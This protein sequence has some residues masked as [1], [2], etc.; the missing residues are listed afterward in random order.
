MV[1]IRP[2]RPV[3][4]SCGLQLPSTGICEPATNSTIGSAVRKR[5]EAGKDLGGRPRRV[6]DSQIRSAV[7]LVKGGEPAGQV[8]RDLGMPERRSTGGHLSEAAAGWVVVA[9]AEFDAVA[10]GVVVAACV[11]PGVGGCFAAGRSGGFAP[12]VVTVGS[13]FS[14]RAVGEY[15]GPGMYSAEWWHLRCFAALWHQKLSESCIDALVAAELN[16]AR[17][18]HRAQ[19]YQEKEKAMTLKRAPMW[20]GVIVLG[21]TLG[22]A[23]A[24]SATI[25]PLVE[26]A[27]CANAQADSH[28]PLGDV[29]DPIGATPGE[30]SHSDQ[31][32]LRAVIVI[33]DGFTDLTSPAL[34]GHKL[35]ETCGK[36]G[37]SER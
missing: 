26:S 5:R 25:H 15:P 36:V 2:G 32:T 24:A 18:R 28:H 23:P 33:S 1:K 10:G 12:G 21:T 30:G 4:D 6:T 34:L 14:L 22:W 8:A 13:G 35:D 27:D 19:S 29:A 11:G 7:R 17:A 37:Q 31:S 3:C 9:G 20:V 16:V